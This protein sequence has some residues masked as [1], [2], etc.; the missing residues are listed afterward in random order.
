MKR[1]S[2]TALVLFAAGSATLAGLAFAQK[3]PLHKDSHEASILR[4]SVVFNR[5]CVTCHGPFGEGNGRAARLHN[6]PPAN[7]RTSDKNDAYIELIVRKGGEAIGRSPAMPPWQDEL[8]DEQVRDLVV[9]VRS[10]N[11]NSLCPEGGAC[12]NPGK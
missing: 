10:I 7:L 2:R 4:G 5:Y 6:P 11:V 9:F 12:A 1:P 3:S 8:T